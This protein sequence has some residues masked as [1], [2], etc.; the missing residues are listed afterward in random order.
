MAHRLRHVA[1][2]IRDDRVF[3]RRIRPFSPV[4]HIMSFRVEAAHLGCTAAQYTLKT[5]AE[6]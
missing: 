5:D 4:S 1:K 2:S 6:S 3:E